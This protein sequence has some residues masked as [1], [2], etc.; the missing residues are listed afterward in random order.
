MSLTKLGTQ[1]GY[2]GPV[3]GSWG[4]ENINP[5]GKNLRPAC[6]GSQQ[7]LAVEN[8]CYRHF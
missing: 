1:I 7:M 6:C 4:I 2:L 5:G 3:T 8:P